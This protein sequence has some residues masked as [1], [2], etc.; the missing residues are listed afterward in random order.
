[1]ASIGT[2]RLGW[3]EQGSPGLFL[4]AGA[5]LLGVL[6]VTAFEQVT[7]TAIPDIAYWPLFPFGVAV[8]LAGL[9]GLYPQ[10]VKRTPRAAKMG[11]GLA[12]SGMVVLLGGLAILLATA[13]SGSYPTSLGPIG[14]P[15]LL[16]LFVFVLAFGAYG[17]AGLRTATPSRGVGSLLLWVAVVQ[18]VELA[19]ALFVFPAAGARTPAQFGWFLAFEAVTYGAIIAAVFGIGYA[20]QTDAF[21][22]ETDERERDHVAV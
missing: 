3:F 5:S 19:G 16:G 4:L 2:Q 14:A 12:L 13:P 11:L 9:V 10:L 18:L 22:P 21:A 15:F 6:A 7:G 17:I 1:M 8:A 20:L